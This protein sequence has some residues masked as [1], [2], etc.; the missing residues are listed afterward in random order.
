MLVGNFNGV[1]KYMPF[2]Q[3]VEESG[4][5]LFAAFFVRDDG[6]SVSEPFVA[7]ENFL[8]QVRICDTYFISTWY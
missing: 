2:Y 3:A 4:P 5:R 1:L 8:D 6:G 7:L